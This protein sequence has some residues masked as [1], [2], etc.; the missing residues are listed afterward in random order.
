MTESPPNEEENSASDD[1]DEEDD[2]VSIFLDF[3]PMANSIILQIN[4]YSITG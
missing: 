1:E 3:I 4:G 2:D